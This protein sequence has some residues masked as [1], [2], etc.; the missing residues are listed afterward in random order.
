MSEEILK[1]TFYLTNSGT[2]IFCN[3]KEIKANYFIQKTAVTVYQ[4]T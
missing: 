4:A 1:N 2:K 3:L